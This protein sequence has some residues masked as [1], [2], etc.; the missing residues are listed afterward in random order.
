LYRAFTSLPWSALGRK[1]KLEEY[2]SI[3]SQARNHA[4]HHALP[5]D[6]TVEVDLSNLDVRA[7]KIRLFL[8]FKEKQ[9]RGVHIKDQ[10]LADVLAEFS[11]AKL[12]PVSMVFWQANLKVMEQSCQL[13]QHILESLI[14]IHQATKS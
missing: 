12:R 7:D 3:V 13:A 2:Q 8:P 4:F 10:K 6:S 9:G 14:L 11:R 1:E 5:F